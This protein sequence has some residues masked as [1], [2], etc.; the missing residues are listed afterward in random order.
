MEPWNDALS[1]DWV[2]QPKLSPNLSTSASNPKSNQTSIGNKDPK[3][4]LP[5][6]KYLHR[7]TA[8]G[9]KS[10]GSGAG[11]SIRIHEVDPALALK[12]RTSSGNNVAGLQSV[13]SSD[14]SHPPTIESVL[15]SRGRHLSRTISTSTTQ[16]TRY[17]TTQQK[18][19][20]SSPPKGRH[21]GSTPEWRR[22]LL[23]SERGYGQ[24]IELFGPTRLENIFRPPTE[25]SEASKLA[26]L[27]IIPTQQ[28]LPS[29]P[30]PYISQPSEGGSSD[31]LAN[32]GNLSLHSGSYWEEGGPISRGLS[33]PGFSDENG[34]NQIATS[35]WRGGR[36]PRSNVDHL[37]SHSSKSS[38]DCPG[39]ASSLGSLREISKVVDRSSGLLG[40]HRLSDDSNA[41]MSPIMVS[42]H[43]TVDGIGFAALDLAESE[44]FRNAGSHIPRSRPASEMSKS[45]A[46]TS[47]RDVSL[48]HFVT[49][50]RGSYSKDGSF[51]KR[52]LSPSS[53]QASRIGDRTQYQATGSTGLVALRRIRRKSTSSTGRSSSTKN[54]P[55]TPAGT[56]LANGGLPNNISGSPMRLFDADND[57]FTR[58]RLFRRLSNI[59][60]SMYP[61]GSSDAPSTVDERAQYNGP[62]D[63]SSHLSLSARVSDT[64]PD[65]HDVSRGN[66]FGQGTFNQY[67]FHIDG[68]YPSFLSD[69]TD[70]EIQ[71]ARPVPLL[72]EDMKSV[73]R[74]F[75]IP[76]FT[77]SR[78]NSRSWHESG[79]SQAITSEVFSKS[80]S[81][82]EEKYCSR[83]VANP[84]EGA[85]IGS[86]R[87]SGSPYKIPTPKRR[88]TLPN[89]DTPTTSRPESSQSVRER[90]I[91]TQSI[92]GKRKDASIEGPKNVANP[93]IVAK[94]QILKPRN[95]LS[96]Q[97]ACSIKDKVNINQDHRESKLEA[98]LDIATKQLASLGMK[99]EMITDSRKGSVTTQDYLDEATRV[100]ELIRSR[101]R[102]QSGLTSEDISE[103]ETGTTA[104]SDSNQFEVIPEDNES[105]REDF[106][107][108]PSREGTRSLPSKDQMQLD[109]QVL[110]QLEK[111]KENGTIG[112]ISSS[113]EFLTLGQNKH[114]TK[115]EEE[116]DES[117]PTNIRIIPSASY[118]PNV[119]D[120]Q[121]ERHSLQSTSSNGTS[122]PA[123]T[124][125]FQTGSSGRS[126]TKRNIPL[127]T[128]SHLIPGQV[129]G[130]IYDGAKQMWVKA[131]D[132]FP[133]SDRD[134]DP[135][136]SIPDL[137]VNEMQELERI[138]RAS[139][140]ISAK[141]TELI[142]MNQEEA[143]KDGND[144]NQLDSGDSLRPVTREGHGQSIMDS[145]SVPSKMS[146]FAS[147]G[148]QPETRA[149]SWGDTVP[150]HSWKQGQSHPS[151]ATLLPVDQAVQIDS[152][153]SQVDVGDQKMQNSATQ[154][155]DL[156]NTNS[157]PLMSRILDRSE[158][159]D[160]IEGKNGR[161]E[162]SDSA[163]DHIGN[164]DQSFMND[165]GQSRRLSFGLTPNSGFRATTRRVSFGGQSFTARPISRIDERSEDSSIRMA[166]NYQRGGSTAFQVTLSTPLRVRDIP[167]SLS[168][169]VSTVARRSQLSFHLSPLPD[170]TINQ[171]D[172][173][174][175]RDIRH[176]AEQ[177]GVL[178]LRDIDSTFGLATEQLIKNV[179]DVEPYEPY[180]DWIRHI[181]LKGKGL[182]TL[183]DLDQFCSRIEKLDVSDNELGQLNGAPTSLRDLDISRNCLSN[184]TTW[185]HLIN[186]Q[187]LDVSGNQLESLAGFAELVHLRELRVDDN[188][189]TSINGIFDLDGLTVLKARRN[190]LQRIDF[191]ASCL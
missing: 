54:T 148:P 146:K 158:S 58:E 92:I 105:T 110:R 163:F 147:S 116:H 76:E 165:L 133:N 56:L 1:E 9:T 173:S 156:G 90:L 101:N 143:L 32:H 115:K 94:R 22:R 86:K 79:V 29:S 100:M 189:L 74:G 164:L 123:T 118:L 43:N 35:T 66:S 179:T 111:Y 77:G 3:S 149:T 96:G 45:Q 157:S 180:W 172:E 16:T 46:T 153:R 15:A 138:K 104:K 145:S 171:I 88:R 18:S 53:M 174:F 107:R 97:A 187:F 11:G 121:S 109:P 124:R 99:K 72:T 142:V 57:T 24:N 4:R 50:R 30:P 125:S 26:R 181:D 10:T 169:P 177:R 63:I 132:A 102:P 152:D 93:E 12:E 175:N 155:S 85:T 69:D 89:D 8:S 83:T 49:T 7:R 68:S 73:L 135:F 113:M 176:V 178:C 106:S 112:M 41:S 64:S 82:K 185:A 183:H 131:K 119:E 71:N 38:L 25:S 161:I 5:Q 139:L 154:S 170:F 166:E 81:S 188:K 44:V 137:S 36:L 17:A 51:R 87:P 84:E 122:G 190:C 162:E 191:E 6:P 117:Q 108:P 141:Q 129:A 13:N 28:L 136:G 39:S 33:D 144:G 98:Q 19:L 127:H 21:P 34:F 59:E 140:H 168:V 61:D 95:R 134:E 67:Q 80:K 159:Y 186:L 20:S 128:V 130:M 47:I 62:K 126:D 120:R 184:L 91:Q 151:V 48:G 182:I 42:K 2:S 160:R 75:Q 27:G 40:D 103:V 52:P 60:D 65:P 78:K 37:F 14:K 31:C 167:G 23:G 70:E 150:P 55:L 114:S